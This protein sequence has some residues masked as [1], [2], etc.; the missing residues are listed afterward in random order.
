MNTQMFIYRPIKTNLVTQR[1]GESRACI[2]INPLLWP[3]R[4]TGKIN[5]I[6]RL[7]SVDFYSSPWGGNMKGH[8]GIDFAA[9]NG[10]PCYFSTQIPNMKWRAKNEIDGAGGLGIDIIS[11]D[12][13]TIGNKT[14]YTK[15][16]FWHMKDSI[17]ADGQEVKFGDLIGHCDN[18][19][20]SGGNHLHHGWKF[21]EVDG[22]AKY[23]DNGYR[24][25]MDPNIYMRNTFVGEITDIVKEQLAILDR[26][27]ILLLQMRIKIQ[28]SA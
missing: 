13:V 3:P 15:F 5:G 25:A 8:N 6:C 28:E 24:G 12:K 16:R 19:G 20:A 2:Q 23:A 4:I 9:W 21:C 26:I 27:R 10:E 14:E 17:V 18:T 1:F 22:T 11:K 7:G